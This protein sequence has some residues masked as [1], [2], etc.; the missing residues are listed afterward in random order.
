MINVDG[1]SRHRTPAND[2][3]KV[4]AY[5]G[6]AYNI[7]DVQA[8]KETIK[9]YRSKDNEMRGKGPNKTQSKL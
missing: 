9:K 3:L 6:V 7:C 1:G 2:A 4:T 5:N 8:T